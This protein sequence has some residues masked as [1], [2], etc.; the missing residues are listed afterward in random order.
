MLRTHT[1]HARRARVD[2]PPWYR[3]TCNNVLYIL[4]DR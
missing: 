3:M 2:D 1:H 4:L